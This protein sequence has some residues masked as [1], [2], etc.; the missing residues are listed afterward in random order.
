MINADQVRPLAVPFYYEGFRRP[1]II[2]NGI[3]VPQ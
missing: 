2:D 1:P 3:E